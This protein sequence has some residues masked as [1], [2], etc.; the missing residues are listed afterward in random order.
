MK[1]R[2]QNVHN[3]SF[4]AMTD[5]GHRGVMSADAKIGGDG[6]GARP[7]EMVL[8]GLGGCSG[9]DVLAMLKKS[10]Q[11]VHPGDIEIEIEAVRTDSIPSLFSRIHVRY[12]I[13]NASIEH[14][15]A[16]RAVD[17]SMQKYCSV[18][19]ILEKTAKITHCVEIIPKT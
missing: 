6:L 3:M 7:M 14:N 16:V 11:P 8:M 18:T 2:L 1:I 19:R 12:L 5:G 10:R 4:E 17:L 13:H 15:K 9:I